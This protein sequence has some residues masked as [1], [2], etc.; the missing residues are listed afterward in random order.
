[1]NE[2]RAACGPTPS[3][4]GMHF[5]YYSLRSYDRIFNEGEYKLITTYWDT[6]VLDYANKEEESLYAE[7]RLRL[8]STPNLPHKIYQLK[9][10]CTNIAQML[11]DSNKVFIDAYGNIKKIKKPKRYR[12]TCCPVLSIIEISYRRYGISFMLDGVVEYF[13][14]HEPSNYVQVLILKTGWLYYASVEE[15]LPDTTRGM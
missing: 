14:H 7:R 13:V 1:M 3:K 4:K 2:V 9:Q 8:L 11:V 5:P 6:Y 12:L 10:R 15:K